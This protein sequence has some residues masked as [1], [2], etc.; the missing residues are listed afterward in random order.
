MAS[1]R[2]KYLKPGEKVALKLSVERLD[3]IVDNVLIDEHIL[4]VI[5][6]ARVRDGVA[7]IRCTLDDLDELAGCVSAQAKHTKDKKLRH[8]LDAISD[9]IDRLNL[10]YAQDTPPITA[11]PRLTLVQ[12]SQPARTL[13]SSNHEPKPADTAGD[14]KPRK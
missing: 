8:K 11:A 4:A 9:E 14:S 7:T 6:A 3:L 10:T 12:K 1:S 5:H 2:P 13:N